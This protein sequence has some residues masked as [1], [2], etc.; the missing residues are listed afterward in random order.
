MV[1]FGVP[2][3]LQGYAL[4]EGLRAEIMVHLHDDFAYR[5]ALFRFMTMIYGLTGTVARISGLCG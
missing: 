1:F 5:G 2:L 4:I 3:F